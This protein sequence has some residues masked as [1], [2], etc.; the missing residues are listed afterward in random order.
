MS[1]SGRVEKSKEDSWLLIECG[2]MKVLIQGVGPGLQ[3]E[4]E[5]HALLEG[6]IPFQADD[7][8]S[9]RRVSL[10]A[11]DM[12]T[13]EEVYPPKISLEAPVQDEA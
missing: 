1:R 5:A 7:I 11:S 13:I 3:S 8:K 2:V 9:I 12:K 6:N 10:D 4:M